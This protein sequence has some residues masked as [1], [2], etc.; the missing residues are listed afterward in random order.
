M[1]YLI[2]EIYQFNITPFQINYCEEY[3]FDSKIM[4]LIVNNLSNLLAYL[5]KCRKNKS[6]DDQQQKS[7]QFK[8][9]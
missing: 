7:I 1:K 9:D 6:F 5:Q 2:I 3:G 8:I 4:F